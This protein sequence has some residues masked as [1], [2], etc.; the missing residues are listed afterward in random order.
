MQFTFIPGIVLSIAL[1]LA[2][3]GSGRA[4]APQKFSQDRF[5]IGFWVDPPA[6]QNMD[7]HYADIAA[8]NFTM[9]IGGFGAGTPE[10]V[11]RQ[12]ALCERWDLKAIVGQGGLP[13]AQLPASSAVWGYKL[14]DEPPAEEFAALR[15]TVAQIRQ[16]R[17]G[18]LSYINLFPNYASDQQ[19]GTTGY[20]EYVTRFMSEVNP[21]VLSMDHYPM[22]TPEEDGR[23]KYCSNLEMMRKYAL[24]HNVP[25]WNYFNTMPFGPHGDPTEAQLK[26]QVYTSIAYGARGVLYFCYWTPRGHE[27]PKG[28]AIITAEGRKTRHYAQAQRINHDLKNLGKTLMQ[29]TSTQVLRIQPDA[30]PEELLTTGPV[31]QLTPG[32]YLIGAFT[33]QDG[34]QAVLLNNY[35]F[36]YTAWPTVKFRVPHNQIREISKTDGSEIEVMDDSPDM[37]G[38]QLSLDAGEGRLFLLPKPAQ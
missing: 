15:D 6:D 22:M 37:E 20:E 9:V 21:D 10:Q 30:N 12:V 33:H 13:H 31:E 2:N 7:Q 5:A 8:A 18:K 38:L 17:P 14:R 36:A 29:L 24:L 19:L 1:V 34:R 11:R 26:W 32:D 28:G 23:I 27:F 3:Y 35:S 16:A 25:F 4:A